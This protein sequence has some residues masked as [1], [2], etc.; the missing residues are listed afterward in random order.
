M[1]R[2]FVIIAGFWFQ[3]RYPCTR[4]QTV[5]WRRVL[6]LLTSVVITDPR[7][8]RNWA[9][10][11]ANEL[12]WHHT[13]ELYITHS[14]RGSDQLPCMHRDVDSYTSW[15][16]FL[17]Y[18]YSLCVRELHRACDVLWFMLIIISCSHT[19]TSSATKTVKSC[20]IIIRIISTL[21]LTHR[22]T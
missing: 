1:S 9:S 4:L 3:I 12:L 22:S 21:L 14:Y 13:L 6:V 10:F 7:A 19:R 2:S 11:H 18:P 16:C 8:V 17:Q 15:Q 5:G 20:C